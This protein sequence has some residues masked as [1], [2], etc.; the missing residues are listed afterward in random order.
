MIVIIV[1][2][3]CTCLEDFFWNAYYK[4]TTSW[5]PFA[6]FITRFWYILFYVD[7][8]Y[9]RRQICQKPP[10][11]NIVI[12]YILKKL[13]CKYFLWPKYNVWLKILECTLSYSS[14]VSF[15]YPFT[16]RYHITWNAPSKVIIPLVRS[17][18]EQAKS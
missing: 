11:K 7:L 3:L 10:Y 15:N 14:Y 2:K 16:V 17:F 6:C 4:S 1:M 8:N 13:C 12:N 18:V 5:L 9:L